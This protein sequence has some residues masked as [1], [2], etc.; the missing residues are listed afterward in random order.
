MWFHAVGDAQLLDLRRQPAAIDALVEARHASFG[1][2]DEWH[3]LTVLLLPPTAPAAGAAHD[4]ALC[5]GGDPIEGATFDFCHGMNSARARAAALA[6]QVL[7]PEGL[8][9]RFESE[10]FR[11]ADA[12]DI[13][14]GAY[15]K[16]P[17]N[18]DRLQ[19][20]FNGMKTFF[21]GAAKRGE[22]VIHYFV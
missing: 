17:A 15:W 21:L 9:E 1:L 2:D 5:F 19:Q 13:Y 20:A 6:L 7:G 12:N 3:A 14:H 16:D 18:F 11:S 10:P 22:G 4:T 8:R